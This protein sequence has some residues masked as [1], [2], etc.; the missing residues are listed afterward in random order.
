MITILEPG[1]LTSVQDLGRKGYQKQGVIVSGVMDEYAHIVAN[2][3]VGNEVSKPTIEIT[4][5]GPSIQFEEDLLIAICGGDFTPMIGDRQVAL[6]RPVFVKK[7]S[8][9][10][11]GYSKSGCRAYISI[12]GGFDLSKVM[13]SKS[14]YLRAGIGGYKGRRLMHGDQIKV[15]KCGFLSQKIIEDIKVDN[16]SFNVT[17][18]YVRPY[19]DTCNN[20]ISVIIGRQFDCFTKESQDSLFNQPFK[21][22]ADSDRM[23]YRLKGPILKAKNKRDMISE[24]TSFGAIQVP[25]GGDPIVLLADRQ[26]VGGYPM[27]AQIIRVDLP[28]FAQL[29]PGEKVCFNKI[30]LEEA[31]SRFLEREI[32]LYQ[33]KKSIDLKYL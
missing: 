16:L 5:L 3:L 26:T 11:F 30:S 32:G 31:Q 24:A 27:I 22:S 14:T 23:G 33:F 19:S 9:L 17:D 25:P 18:W 4:I 15:E 21:I 13:G 8:L 7:G 20:N 29:K 2:L 28:K 6:W 10:K 1:L 12:A